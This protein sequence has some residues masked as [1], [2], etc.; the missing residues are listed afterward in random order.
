MRD[1]RITECEKLAKLGTDTDRF[2]E[3]LR[4]RN[5]RV[6]C[7]PVAESAGGCGGTLDSGVA[8]SRR[9]YELDIDGQNRLL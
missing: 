1:D 8:V 4:A 3:I 6:N 5:G 2:M 7:A 9:T